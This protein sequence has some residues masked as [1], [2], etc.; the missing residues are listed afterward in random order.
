MKFQGELSPCSYVLK[1]NAWKTG[2]Q[3]QK[4]YVQ[5]QGVWWLLEQRELLTVTL[6]K[7]INPCYF[8]FDTIM[9]TH[10][11]PQASATIKMILM[12][13][14]TKISLLKHNNLCASQL[15]YHPS[16]KGW[17]QGE[18]YYMNKHETAP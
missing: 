17:I 1:N 3:E 14:M 9:V 10:R 7:R 4:I 15:F 16:L 13:L 12:F 6:D 2:I 11:K 18:M 8:C 5:G